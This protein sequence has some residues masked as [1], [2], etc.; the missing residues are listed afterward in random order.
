M[1][2]ASCFAFCMFGENG[3]VANLPPAGFQHNGCHTRMETDKEMFIL[4][5]EAIVQNYFHLGN[6]FQSN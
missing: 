4:S 6:F 2:G 5:L 1:V 3:E